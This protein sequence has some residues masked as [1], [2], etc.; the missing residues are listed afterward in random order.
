[1][2]VSHSLWL[3]PEREI[4]VNGTDHEDLTEKKKKKEIQHSTFSSR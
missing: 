4:L 3:V 1:M 2:F